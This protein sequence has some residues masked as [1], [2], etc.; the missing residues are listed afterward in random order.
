M[1]IFSGDDIKAQVANSMAEF[2]KFS[3]DVENGV[4]AAIVRGALAVEADAKRLFKGRE[5]ASVKGEPPR[6]DTGRLRASIT[7]RGQREGDEFYA[8]VGTNVEYARDVEE[9]T[10]RTW[11]HPFLVP[12]LAMNEEKI[13][14]AIA[15]AVQ[16]AANA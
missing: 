16:E 14:E 6:V 4:E 8:E 10:S 1:A 5:D 9:G 15:R 12:A 2:R 13:Q 3:A 7:H 11:P